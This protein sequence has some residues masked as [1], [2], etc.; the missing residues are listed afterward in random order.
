MISGPWTSCRLR[1]ALM[2]MHPSALGLDGWSFEDLSAARPVL[3]LAN[4][5]PIGGGAP[6]VMALMP[7]L[8]LHGPHPQGAPSEVAEHLA[9][10]SPLHDLPP[11]G[12]D[13]AGGGHLV[14]GGL[15]TPVCLWLP[16][17]A[18]RLGWRHSA[19]GSL[20]AV[21]PQGVGD[22]GDEHQLRQVF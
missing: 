8:G 15:G 2:R 6:G 7:R 17:R 14:V 1:R 19:P 18:E 5:P 13:Q 21:P 22:G 3:G 9:L 10:N 11:L 20:G 12:G 16:P 4:R